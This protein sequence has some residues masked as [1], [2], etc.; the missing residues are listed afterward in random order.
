MPTCGKA[1]NPD[2]GGVDV[3]VFCPFANGLDRLLRILKSS[4]LPV[5]HGLIAGYPVFQDDRR[6]AHLREFLCNVRSFQ[7]DCFY[8]VASA[9]TD[10]DSRSICFVFRW[11]EEGERRPGYFAED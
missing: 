1:H 10:D 8:P 3:P 5:D 6:D 11:Q 7:V 9:R 4:Y 2:P